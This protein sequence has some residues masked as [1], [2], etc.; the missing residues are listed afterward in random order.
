MSP[1]FGETRRHFSVASLP[2]PF[3]LLERER[4]CAARDL[5]P[6]RVEGAELEDVLAAQIRRVLLDVGEHV[7]ADGDHDRAREVRAHTSP[8]SAALPIA[9]VA[10][11]L[12]ADRRGRCS[13]SSPHAFMSPVGSAAIDFICADCSRDDRLDCAEV[14]WR[15]HGRG[16]A[17]VLPG[18]HELQLHIVVG[19]LE[20][21]D[22]LAVERE[23]LL[24]AQ[25]ERL[26]IEAALQYDE[27]R[28]T[29]FSPARCA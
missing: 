27:I 24:V 23:D 12:P 17:P 4:C 14:G 6:L 22:L 21:I 26:P 13:L 7:V 29:F 10:R 1:A 9:S 16:Q 3:D 2:V 11:L 25:V 15:L 8:L 18:L 28:K 5:D 19:D 20:S